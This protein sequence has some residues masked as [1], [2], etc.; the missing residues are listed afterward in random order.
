MNILGSSYKAELL[1]QIPAENLPKMF[2]GNCECEGGCQLSDQGPWNDEKYALPAQP[3][4]PTTSD[5][6][7]TPE[8]TVT[9]VPATVTA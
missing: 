8:T 3:A 4:T 1:A 9:E 5:P 2:G 6:E 7:K